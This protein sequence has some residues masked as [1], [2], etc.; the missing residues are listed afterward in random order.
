VVYF[1]PRTRG[2]KC[3]CDLIVR[4]GARYVGDLISRKKLPQLEPSSELDTLK[5]TPLVTADNPEN[6]PFDVYAQDLQAEIDRLK[7]SSEAP[8][9]DREALAA[10][11]RIVPSVDE[12]QSTLDQLY[13]PPTGN[14]KIGGQASYVEEVKD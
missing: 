13:G 5:E 14:T 3:A 2:N 7:N 12:I 11:E 4:D 8:T 10:A 1:F 6:T 9:T